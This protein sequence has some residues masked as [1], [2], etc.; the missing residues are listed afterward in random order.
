[1]K[2]ILETSL[3]HLDDTWF[4]LDGRRVSDEYALNLIKRESNPYKTKE[5]EGVLVYMSKLE[6]DQL[7]E[8]SG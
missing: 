5:D 6:Y 8:K 4:S 2:R 7:K 3:G 1:M